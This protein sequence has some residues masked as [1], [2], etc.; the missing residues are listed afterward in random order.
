MTSVAHASW[1]FVRGLETIR[2]VLGGEWK[3]LVSGPGV[4]RWS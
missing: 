1:L 4:K 3:L 2:V